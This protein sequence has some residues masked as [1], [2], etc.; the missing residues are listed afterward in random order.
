MKKEGRRPSFLIYLQ[1]KGK[2]CGL[3]IG[4]RGDRMR[5]AEIDHLLYRIAEGDNRAFERLYEGTKRGVFSFLY[6]YFHHYADTEDAMQTVYLNIKKG[7]GTYRFGSNGSAWILQIAKNHALNEIKKAKRIT[8]TDEEALTNVSVDGGFDVGSSVME[9]MERVLS[10]E[11]QR[12]VTLHVLWNY[13]HRE[14]GEQL[15]CPT[16]TVTS[17]YKRA[18]EKLKKT[19][20]EE[21]Q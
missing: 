14:I 17:K 5:K 15:D 9:T 21:E 8:Y 6:T 16:G 12:I 19:L 11:E 1:Q 7:I 4:E 18:I 20:K 2:L 13:K 3:I 10:E